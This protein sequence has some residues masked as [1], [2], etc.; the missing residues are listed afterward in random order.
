M[1]I[2]Y[3]LIWIIKLVSIKELNLFH[4][5]I[6]QINI[7]IGNFIN[8]SIIIFFFMLFYTS[9]ILI[10][11]VHSKKEIKELVCEGNYYKINQGIKN[12]IIC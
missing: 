3:I 2:C 5:M 9:F 12:S 10:S 6:F 11:Y 8:M 4:Y 1:F 7:L